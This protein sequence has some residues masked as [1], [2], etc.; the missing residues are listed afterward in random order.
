[1]YVLRHDKQL[2]AILLCPR[3]SLKHL[4]AIISLLCAITR[5]GLGFRPLKCNQLPKSYSYNIAKQLKTI[6]EK[7]E[8]LAFWTKRILWLHICLRCLISQEPNYFPTFCDMVSFYEATVSWSRPG[9]SATSV[10]KS[11]RKKFFL[12]VNFFWSVQPRFCDTAVI[13]C[14][15]RARSKE[16]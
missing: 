2:W 7:Y 8:W 5:S 15:Q 16:S 3:Q 1:M 14:A 10:C 9:V 4:L 6:T 12:T 13:A 11:S